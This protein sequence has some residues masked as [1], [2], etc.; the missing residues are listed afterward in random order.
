MGFYPKK[1]DERLS[2]VR[3]MRPVKDANCR[4][5]DVSFECGSA[6]SVELHI[7][8]EPASV[9]TGCF[10]SNGCGYMIAA[11]DVFLE[12]LRSRPLADL[13]S[14]SEQETG[15]VLFEGIGEIPAGRQ[16]C[17]DLALSAF[18][19]A[20]AGYRDSVV[21]EYQG[22]SPLVCSCFGVSEETVVN[23]IHSADDVSV[24]SVGDLCRAGTG[25]G[26]CRM[27]IMEIIDDCRSQV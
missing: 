5:R 22:D 12:Y 17:A 10:R 1:V 13:G 16:Q 11:A 25:C 27:I 2:S 4:G 9:I 8:D 23:V 14:L 24:E 15:R 26:S 18:R 7:A 21:K 6:I 19:K 3:H 20:L